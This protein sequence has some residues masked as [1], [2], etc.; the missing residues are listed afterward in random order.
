[1]GQSTGN[2]CAS[3]GSSPAARCLGAERS[4]M[5]WFVVTQISNNNINKYIYIQYEFD[6]IVDRC[7]DGDIDRQTYIDRQIDR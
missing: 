4:P 1:M 5:A 7:K 6:K 3:G 2:A